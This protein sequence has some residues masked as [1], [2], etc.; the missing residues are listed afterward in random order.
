MK[1]AIIKS[2][3][4]SFV[5][6]CNLLAQTGSG[7]GAK[8]DGS[9]LWALEWVLLTIAVMVVVRALASAAARAAENKAAKKG[10]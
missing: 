5:I 3:L 4:L 8:G 1:P 2:F 10:P 6:P 7:S 9:P